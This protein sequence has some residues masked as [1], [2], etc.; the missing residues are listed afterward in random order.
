MNA[1]Q[2]RQITELYLEMYDGMMRVARKN[3]E[4]EALAEEAVQE[5]FC[6]ACQKLDDC[7]GSPNPRGWLMSTL[8]N[9]ILNAR[10]KRANGRRLIEKYLATKYREAAVSENRL[11][12]NILYG[13]TAESD[14][15][16]LL[17]EMAVEGRSHAEMAA[18]RG[19]SV[20]ACKK[21]VQRA[22]E[23]LKKYLKEDVTK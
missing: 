21:R 9:V 3:E 16:Q 22:R 17:V 19:I 12:L 8:V 13:K 1:E 2:S 23:E 14:A 4:S 10:K 20:D 11:D 15:F 5:A 7:L 18:S 6:I